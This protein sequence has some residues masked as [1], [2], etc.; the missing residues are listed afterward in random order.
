VSKKLCISSP[1]FNDDAANDEVQNSN[2]SYNGN[3]HELNSNS[4]HNN[5]GISKVKSDGK[6]G[7]FLVAHPNEYK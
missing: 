7:V 6:G 3:H 5:I 4:N 2:S 1:L